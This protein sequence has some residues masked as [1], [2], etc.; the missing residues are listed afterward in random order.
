MKTFNYVPVLF[1]MAIFHTSCSGQVGKEADNDEIAKA[2]KVEVFY[3]HYTRRCVT[4]QAVE[5]ESK[6][7]VEELFGG[8]V[9][10]TGYNLEEPAGEKKGKE[11]GVS[12][13]TLLIVKGDTRI[14]ITNE[15]FM[16]ARSNPEKLKEIMREKIEK[17][18]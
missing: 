9:S 13:Q 6:K 17:I 8:K 15:G 1:I 12:G 11:L 2:D 14:N 18:L 3:F 7:A 4:C 16:Y 5:N 10:F